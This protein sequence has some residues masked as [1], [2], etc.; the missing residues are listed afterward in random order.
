M[1]NPKEDKVSE[2]EKWLK[3]EAE[4][5]NLEFTDEIVWVKPDGAVPNRIGGFERHRKPR[6]YKPNNVTESILVFQKKA[7]FLVDK[8]LKNNSYVVTYDRT[9]LWQ[10]NPETNSKHPA[11]FPLNL[12]YKIVRYYSYENEL[13]YDP[14]MGSGTTAVACKNLNRNYI[15]SE[16]SKEYCDI[17]EQRLR[18]EI[19]NETRRS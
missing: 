6:A 18:Q 10:I 17:A 8:T 7:T 3:S 1:S 9:N 12:V 19:Q 11:P 5:H 13:V 16:I 4:K 14:F 2:L 15:G